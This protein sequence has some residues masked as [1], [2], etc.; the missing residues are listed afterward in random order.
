MARFQWDAEGSFFKVGRARRLELVAAHGRLDPVMRSI[1]TDEMKE[2]GFR[3]LLVSLPL[4]WCGMWAGGPLALLLVPL[5]WCALY[6]A[7]DRERR[8]LALYSCGGFVMLAL[9]GLV[10]NHYTRYNLILIGPFAA[11]GAW[12]MLSFARASL[13]RRA[14]AP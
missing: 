11:A 14:V 9:H 4:A 6:R 8:L 10:A 1:I 12:M 13:R 3:H 7:E 2:K 5:F